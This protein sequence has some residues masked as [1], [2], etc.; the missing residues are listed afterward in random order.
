MLEFFLKELPAEESI[1]AL[2]SEDC[3]E[4][5]KRA[6]ITAKKSLDIYLLHVIFFYTPHN[7]VAAV[8]IRARTD[9]TTELL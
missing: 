3:I 5:T 6:Q 1:T 4:T 7:P 2:A 9:P 8:F